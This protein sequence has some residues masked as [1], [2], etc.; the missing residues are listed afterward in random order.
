MWLFSTLTVLNVNKIDV[1]GDPSF[2]LKNDSLMSLET[3]Y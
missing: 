1:T 3:R 2:G